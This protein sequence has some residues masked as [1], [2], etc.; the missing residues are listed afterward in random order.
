MATIRLVYDTKYGQTQRIA[1]HAAAVAHGRGHD[2]QAVRVDAMDALD[3]A[4]AVVVLCPIFF[5]KHMPS[6]RRFVARHR[7]ALSKRPTAFFSV[8]GSAASKNA[9]DQANAEK[10]ARDFVASMRWQ[11]NVITSVAGAMAFPRY[12]PLLRFVMKRISRKEGGPTDTTRSH[13]LT[14]W[15]TVDRAMLDLLA[16]LELEEHP[17]HERRRSLVAVA[18]S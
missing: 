1:E 13:E 16:P 5:G 3:G 11:P 14:D 4:D 18:S 2:A 7:D 15:S 17:Q 10:I 6:I 8:C 12:N 9:A